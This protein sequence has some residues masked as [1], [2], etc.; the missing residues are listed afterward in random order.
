VVIKII[1]DVMEYHCFNGKAYPRFDFIQYGQHA[2]SC[3]CTSDRE[4]SARTSE[5]ST[6][7]KPKPKPVLILVYM[8]TQP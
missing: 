8:W 6:G 3:A 7:H 5:A 1:S 4:H 2:L